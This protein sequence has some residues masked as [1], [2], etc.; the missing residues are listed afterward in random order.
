MC[1]KG[2]NLQPED[3]LCNSVEQDAHDVETRTDFSKSDIVILS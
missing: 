3:Y 1:L 2:V